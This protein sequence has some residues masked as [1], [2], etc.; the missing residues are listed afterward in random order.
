MRA[1]SKKYSWYNIAQNKPFY[2]ED[3]EILNQQRDNGDE[4]IN[5][6]MDM[7]LTKRKIAK[8]IPKAIIQRVNKGIKK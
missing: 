5:V 2:W 4:C 1:Q 7:F 6:E 8:G 3:K